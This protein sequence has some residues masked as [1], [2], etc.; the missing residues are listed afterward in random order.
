ME[1]SCDSNK[2]KIFSINVKARTTTAVAL[3]PTSNLDTLITV[4][5]QFGLLFALNLVSGERM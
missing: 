1:K 3:L 4:R 2:R 5:F